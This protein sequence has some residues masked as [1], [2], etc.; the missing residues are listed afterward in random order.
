LNSFLPVLIT[1][2]QQYSYPAL[3]L[4]VFIAAIGTPLPVSFVLLAAGAFAALGDFNLVLLALI[5]VSAAV[6]GDNVG[7]L[8]GRRG[9]A[10]LF[11]WLARQRRFQ[12]ISPRA[13][14]RSRAYFARR[15]GWAIFLSRCIFTALGGVI[16]L[17]AGAELYPYRRFLVF[18]IAG[19][20][21]GML[22][23]LTLG[24][25]FETSWEAVG[26]V[27]AALSI[28]LTAL[29]VAIYFALLLVRMTRRVKAPAVTRAR[30]PAQVLQQF[31]SSISSLDNSQE[32]P[33][34]LSP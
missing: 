23:P 8:I 30:T 6:A 18:D 20:A 13:V 25:I 27:L 24:Y 9:G 12:V 22:F 10:R 16:N 28:F 5:A 32:E 3:W 34:S 17:L 14:E 7:Y 33:D 31:R 4:S 26:N 2:L 29:V 19:E 1:W 15:G 11:T 21:L